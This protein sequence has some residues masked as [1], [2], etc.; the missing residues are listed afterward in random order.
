LCSIGETYLVP[1]GPDLHLFIVV[2]EEDDNGMHILV[3]VSSIDPHIHYDQTCEF[4]GGEH[5]F[6]KHPSFAAYDFAIQR[7]KNFIDDKAKR[8]VY[9]RHKDAKPE[10]VS[11]IAN[12]I[13][14]SSFTKR[15]I[16]D[17]YD[18]C[19]RATEKR[20]NRQAP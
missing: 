3:S 18:A 6:I 10:V 7:H 1:S 14:K 17:G 15:A 13:R 8:G 20:Q 2:T 12:G 11:K 4:R 16:K 19:I 9:K 5:D